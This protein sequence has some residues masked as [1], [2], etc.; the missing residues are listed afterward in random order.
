MAAVNAITT[1]IT[2][3]TDTSGSNA[4]R[5]TSSF[6]LPSNVLIVL[7]ISNYNYNH[8]SGDAVYTINGG[9]EVSFGAPIVNQ[10]STNDKIAFFAAYVVTGG[11]CII[12]L[13]NCQYDLCP[14]IVLD[15]K[16]QYRISFAAVVEQLFITENPASSGIYPVV[17]NPVSPVFNTEIPANITPEH[18]SKV[19]IAVMTHGPDS[20]V[21]TITP[22][23]TWTISQNEQDYDGA[24]QPGLMIYK[25]VPDNNP[26]TADIQVN[27]SFRHT[28]GLIVVEDTPEIY[29]VMG[30]GSEN[31]TEVEGWFGHDGKGGEDSIARIIFNPP[32]VANTEAVIGMTVFGA[33]PTTSII[34][35]DGGNTWVMDGQEAYNSESGDGNGG[36]VTLFRSTLTSPMSVFTYDATGLAGGANGR[37]GQLGAYVFEK[38]DTVNGV[39]TLTPVSDA[40]FSA[41]AVTPGS[42]APDF[43]LTFWIF[44]GANRGHTEN[45]KPYVKPSGY[46]TAKL[47]HSGIDG[48]GAESAV[49]DSITQSGWWFGKLAA[50]LDTESPVF[51]FTGAATAEVRSML[52]GYNIL[53]GA[54]GGGGDYV[55]GVLRSKVF[56]SR[57]LGRNRNV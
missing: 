3:I 30:F 5:S 13:K 44:L 40:Q 55:L 15:C 57:V 23:G 38:P 20:G 11:T 31:T 22:G 1:S 43:D 28:L 53:G 49:H 33:N 35:D 48:D 34:S 14:P 17:S 56:S 41:N 52:M 54:A 36:S 21:P 8:V 7:P 47:I 2:R 25:Q 46:T 19:A 24:F 39:K 10:G 51:E 37:Y 27:Q 45:L 18:S 4:T 9:S 16:S 26:V 42:L 12:S 50:N 32:L 6:T 29:M